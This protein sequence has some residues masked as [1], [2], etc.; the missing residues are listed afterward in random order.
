VPHPALPTE[1]H[2]DPSHPDPSGPDPSGP[3]S[4]GSD[5][6]RADLDELGALAAALARTGHSLQDA[7]AA[8]RGTTATSIGTDRL[9]RACQEFQQ[10]WGYRLGQLQRQLDDTAEGVRDTA[11]GYRD[12]EHGAVALLAALPVPV[13]GAD[14]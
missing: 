11:R 13:P 4:F 12:T 8:L 9:D 10:H 7:L 14:R 3:G 1:P 2:P 5:S 6:F